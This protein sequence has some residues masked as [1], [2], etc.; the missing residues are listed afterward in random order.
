MAMPPLRFKPLGPRICLSLGRRYFTDTHWSASHPHLSHFLPWTQVA[1]AWLPGFL[2]SLDI[3]PASYL[4]SVPPC[5]PMRNLVRPLELDTEVGFT[6]WRI[7]QKHLQ[8][9]HGRSRRG[10]ETPTQ[11]P[12]LVTPLRR[13]DRSWGSAA[14]LAEPASSASSILR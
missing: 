6:M 7:F 14:S 12:G 5:Q 9:E 11:G 10:Q 4:G 3:L 13:R 1:R 2:L 8:K